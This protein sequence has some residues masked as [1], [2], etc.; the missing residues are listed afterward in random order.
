MAE[1]SMNCSWLT[2]C[3]VVA[4]DDG[5]VESWNDASSVASSISNPYSVRSSP[6]SLTHSILGTLTFPKAVPEF[7]QDDYTNCST[8]SQPRSRCRRGTS[9][10]DFGIVRKMSPIVMTK[11]TISLK[12]YIPIGQVVPIAFR[13]WRELAQPRSGQRLRRRDLHS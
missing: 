4:G 5:D 13:K 10:S 11:S 7:D 1:S 2:S 3:A 12:G 9:V 6:R 8:D